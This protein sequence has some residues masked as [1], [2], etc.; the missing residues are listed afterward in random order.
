MNMPK[1]KWGSAPKK[2]ITFASKIKEFHNTLNYNI[3]YII[4]LLAD[5]FVLLL[6]KKEQNI[7]TH[8]T[9]ISSQQLTR[10]AAY[11][12]S[13]S[14]R[15]FEMMQILSTQQQ[16]SPPRIPAAQYLQYLISRA[17]TIL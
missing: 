5:S 9:L 15:E 8:T 10:L 11:A 13:H 14:P 6:E 3:K 2:S 12:K 17:V 4:I 7:Q 16:Y 1:K